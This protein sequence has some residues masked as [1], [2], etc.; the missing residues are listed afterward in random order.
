MTDPIHEQ[1]SAFLDGELS[2][3]ESELLLK[4]V[5]RDPELKVRLERYVLAGEALRATAVQSRPSRDFSARIAASIDRETAPGRARHVAQWLKP[6]AGGA[7]AAGVAA[8]ALVSFQ[9]TPMLTSQEAV[10]GDDTATVAQTAAPL[11]QSSAGRAT[12]VR[13]TAA[14]SSF[15]VPIRERRMPPPIQVVNNGRLANFV[16]AHSEYSSPLGRRNVLTGLVA[17]DVPAD[18]PVEQFVV[19]Q[20]AVDEST[21]SAPAPQQGSD[22]RGVLSRGPR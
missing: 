2:A 7:I 8:V 16:V 4:R 14:D 21:L 10:R 19:E 3:V 15:T 6:V 20:L 1:L 17:D 5:A 13:D 11:S 18:Q 9:V 22:G 12:D